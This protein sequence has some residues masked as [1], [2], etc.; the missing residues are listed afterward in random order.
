M[1]A[2]DI[3]VTDV[4]TVTPEMTVAE[5]AD[6][7]LRYRIH[8]AP[9]VGPADTLVGMVSLV[10]LV[11]RYGDTVGEVMSTDPVTADEDTPVEDVAR[12]ML[13]RMVRR[14]PI[15][16]AGRVVGIISASDIIQLFLNLHDRPLDRAGS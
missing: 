10:D 8:G 9:V 3:M 11:G 5:A 16:R 2:R 14:V 6:V 4:V 12:L 15:V 7:L 13:D 1:E